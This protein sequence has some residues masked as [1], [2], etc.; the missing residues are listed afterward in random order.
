MTDI[1]C[2]ICLQ[3]LADCKCLL[4]DIDEED[5]EPVCSDCNEYLSDCVCDIL[6]PCC[7]KLYVGCNCDDEEEDQIDE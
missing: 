6:C 1:V 5:D 7:G 4:E 2:E 3:T